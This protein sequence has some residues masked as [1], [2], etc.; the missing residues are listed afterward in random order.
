MAAMAI[1]CMAQF[2]VAVHHARMNGGGDSWH[3]VIRD[4][5]TVGA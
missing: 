2:V 3:D 5:R 1:R 4:A